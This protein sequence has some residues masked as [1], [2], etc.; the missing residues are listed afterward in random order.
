MYVNRCYIVC[1]HVIILTHASFYTQAMSMVHSATDPVAR[2]LARAYLRDTVI[3]SEALGEFQHDA[4]QQ[5]AHAAGNTLHTVD[6]ENDHTLASALQDALNEHIPLYEADQG[7]YERSAPTITASPTLGSPGQGSSGVSSADKRVMCGIS[8][9]RRTP[10]TCLNRLVLSS[11]PSTPL[12]SHNHD[13]TEDT[14]SQR[15]GKGIASSRS[16]SQRNLERRSTTPR[17]GNGIYIS[18]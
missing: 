11:A 15:D 5:R 8:E 10:P 17:K 9:A 18:G 14:P 4:H 2:Q 16:P 13:T 12:L 6:T 1:R 3:E 7:A